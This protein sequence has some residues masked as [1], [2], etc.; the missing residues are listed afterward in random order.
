MRARAGS[1]GSDAHRARPLQRRE[2]I[3]SFASR[4]ILCMVGPA[5][6]PR[7]AGHACGLAD[8]F[9]PRSIPATE[10]AR[11]PPRSIRDTVNSC[12]DG[13]GHKLSNFTPMRKPDFFYYI[14][15]LW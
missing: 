14:P 8:P 6:F 7:R 2:S 4:I 11:A 9:H 5:Q 15:N 13:K 3:P 1:C 10:G 12:V